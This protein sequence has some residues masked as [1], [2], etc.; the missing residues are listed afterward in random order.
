[1]F[2][3][4]KCK[5]T[6]QFI[7]YKFLRGMKRFCIKIKIIGPRFSSLIQLSIIQ[8]A[9]LEIHEENLLD[10]SEQLEFLIHAVEGAK[11]DYIL[12]LLKGSIS[13]WIWNTLG[14]PVGIDIFQWHLQ[15]NHLRSVENIILTS[16]FFNL[17]S[18]NALYSP[19]QSFQ[20]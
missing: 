15:H 1:M 5:V 4:N 2:F 17:L 10:V 8:V 11:I 16:C 18:V 9:P 14:I 7:P 12:P 6:S 19:I 3:L 13:S 20:V